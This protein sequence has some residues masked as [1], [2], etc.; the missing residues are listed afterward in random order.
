MMSFLGAGGLHKFMNRPNG[1]LITDSGGKIQ[2][3]NEFI[4]C[5]YN[6]KQFFV[7]LALG[8]QVRFSSSQHFSSILGR[9]YSYLQ[10]YS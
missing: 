3:L 6:F 2:R 7:P 8:F 10:C 4:F 1:P 5:V 9:S